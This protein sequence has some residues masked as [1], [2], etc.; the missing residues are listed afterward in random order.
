MSPSLRAAL[1]LPLVLA[2]L[3]GGCGDEAPS[4]ARAARPAPKAH[5]VAALQVAPSAVPITH[6]RPGSLRYRRLVRVFNQEEGRITALD[7]YEGDRV[8]RGQLLVALDDRLL[9]AEIAAAHATLEQ[10]ELDLKRL[11]DLRARRAVSESEVSLARTA[12]RVA[13]A[14]LELLET[15]RSFTRIEAPFA[16]VITERLVEPGD[17]VS[18]NTQ[19][20]AL[21]DPGSLVAEVAASELLLPHLAVGDAASLRID[22]LGAQRFPARV[23]RIHPSL[24]RRTR[25]GI[26]ELAL[27]PIPA[28]ARAGQFVR[29]RLESAPV[30]RL[31]IPFNALRRD[32]QGEFV[33]LIDAQ[34]RAARRAV[35]SGLQV[36]DRVEIR[37]GLAPGERVI[38]RGFLGLRAGKA[39]DVVSD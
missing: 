35:R 15:R 32:R 3:L 8:E 23:L 14:E 33:W 19:L 38:T 24:E 21:A 25:Q 10:A 1:S 22:A 9:E 13:R 7:L 28:G 37:D 39:V 12:L 36:E 17:F 26:V 11:E 6:E 29:A 30:A 2:L 4:Q 27:D 31:L 18:K 34:G 20:L 5:L 16:G